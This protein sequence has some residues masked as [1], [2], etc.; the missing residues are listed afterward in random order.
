MPHQIVKVKTNDGLTLHGLLSE[1]KVNPKK[2]ITIHIHGTSGNFY[3]SNFFNQLTQ[4]ALNLKISYLSTNNRGANVYEIERDTIPHG[5]AIEHFEDSMLDIDAWIEFVLRSGYKKVILEGHSLGTE[6]V[7]YYMKNGK[8]KDKICAIILLGFSDTYGTQYK[9]LQQI[10]KDYMDEAKA[11]IVQK[12]P[13]Q[14]LSDIYGQAGEVPISASTYVNFFSS[15]SELSKSFPLRN[16]KKLECY[17]QI[18]VPILG[19]IGD[20]YECEYTIVPIKD[21][22]ELLKRENK[23]ADVYQIKDCDHLFTNKEYELTEI[24]S[25]FI[26][27]RVIL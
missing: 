7:V 6:K 12:K 1:A 25:G 22:I 8:Y 24:I 2:I 16:G 19:V 13:Y 3:W 26:K 17:R 4:L 21:A 5:A 20:K 10:G 15:D 18:K 11:Y 27:R 14:L 23:L 9:Y